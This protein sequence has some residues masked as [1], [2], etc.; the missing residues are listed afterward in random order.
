MNAARMA[1]WSDLRKRALELEAAR[2]K[3]EP[4]PKVEQPISDRVANLNSIIAARKAD[5]ERTGKLKITKPP[6][7]YTKRRA[8]RDKRSAARRER[9]WGRLAHFYDN[10][11]RAELRELRIE[12]LTAAPVEPD[13]F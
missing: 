9:D 1:Y 6:I 13:L 10:L 2:P 8:D 12:L 7:D 5:R 4:T 11:S 3:P